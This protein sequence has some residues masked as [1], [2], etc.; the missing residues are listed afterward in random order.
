MNH[1]P[2]KVKS[3]L[4]AL[5]KGQKKWAGIAMTAAALASLFALLLP[6]AVRVIIDSIIGDQPWAL[7]QWLSGWLENL[8]GRPFLSRYFVW[9]ILAVLLLALFNSLFSFCRTY[10]AQMGAEG[11]IRTLRNRLMRHLQNLSFQGHNALNTGD[12]I[13]RC[14]TDVDLLRRFCAAQVP[15]IARAVSLVVLSVWLML[16]VDGV[17]TAVTAATLPVVAVLS[18]VYFLKV[19]KHFLL[20]DE[21]EGYLSAALQE[22]LSGVRVI[23]SFGRQQYVTDHFEA[24]NEESTK[25]YL[26]VNNY[27]GDFWGATDAIGYFQVGL[28]LSV[29][30]YLCI[31]G[32]I[33]LGDLTLFVSYA[34]ILVWPVRQLGRILS[35]F[36][37]AKVSW[38]RLKWILEQPPEDEGGQL[39]FVHG[40]I[41][42]DRVTFGYDPQKPVLRDISFQIP[43]GGTLAI[44]GGTAS[45]KSTLVQLLARLYDY[46]GGSITV[47]GVELNQ[48][49]RRSLRENVGLILQEPFLYSRSVRD[50]IALTR[51]D[52]PLEQVRQAAGIAALDDVV[53][54]FDEGY[55]TMVGE[56]G[57]TLSGGQKQRVALART[58][59][60]Q[61]PVIILDDSL[62]AVD[63]KTDAAIRAALKKR[64]PGQT[65]VII[66]HRIRT[67]MAA[68]HIIVLENG[69]IAQQGTSEE[70]LREDGLFRDIYDIQNMSLEAGES[71]AIE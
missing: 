3:P 63:T 26:K 42:F 57:I 50:N 1:K 13:Q 19:Q 11:F 65:T 12:I 22:D 9:C 10:F 14:T 69:R 48:I 6:M 70:L 71:C 29:G 4:R 40:D 55:E 68:D 39:E 21:A 53:T 47:G 67:L 64:R 17:M 66:S 27:M 49:S 23:R 16:G 5:L 59:L 51:P 32:R 56:R 25:L 36:G 46:Q 30:A 20:A 37:K 45:G 18:V 60:R 52:A 33:T 28:S 7:P 31:T 43:K 54:G 34:G 2:S 35:D 62:S 41:V 61:T 24:L 8:G 38:N 44:L 15:E 58:L